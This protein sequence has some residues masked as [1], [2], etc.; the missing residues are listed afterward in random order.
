MITERE[1]NKIIQIIYITNAE[2]TQ[3]NIGGI[4]QKLIEEKLLKPEKDRSKMFHIGIVFKKGKYEYYLDSKKSSKKEIDKLWQDNEPEQSTL[5]K[6]RKS[7]KRCE[8]FYDKQ[9]YCN[10]MQSHIDTVC[11]Y[12]KTIRELQEKENTESLLPNNT[13][14]APEGQYRRSN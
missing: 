3:M 1:L 12:E 11:F 9:Q 6:A 10:C 2:I 14:V 4:K 13:I 5:E 7:N 8:D